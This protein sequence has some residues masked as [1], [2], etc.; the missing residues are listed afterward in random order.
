M[1]VCLTIKEEFDN[2][3]NAIKEL[4]ENKK[5]GRDINIEENK[6]NNNNKK[7]NKFLDILEN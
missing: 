3:E 6:D 5:K 7:S 1:R 2:K 4:K